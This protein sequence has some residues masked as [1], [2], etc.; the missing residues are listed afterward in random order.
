MKVNFENL[1]CPFLPLKCS[2]EWCGNCV[3]L[4][5][6]KLQ[7]R[8]T[9]NLSLI[10]VEEHS[11]C[12][13][14]SRLQ[15]V[16][17][18]GLLLTKCSPFWPLVSNFFYFRLKT[19][20]FSC[21]FFVTEKNFCIKILQKSTFSRNPILYTNLKGVENVIIEFIGRECVCRVK[22]TF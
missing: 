10:C 21:T 22:Y 16:V 3:R 5:S 6:E 17:L 8:V 7:Y 15:S 1:K 14:T 12:L 13:V 11:G 19:F 18:V 9:C 4:Y 2:N 20:T